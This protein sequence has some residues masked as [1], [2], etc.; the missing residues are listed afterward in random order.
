MSIFSFGGKISKGTVMV[1]SGSL[2]Y[3]AIQHG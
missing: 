1:F 2:L 3:E